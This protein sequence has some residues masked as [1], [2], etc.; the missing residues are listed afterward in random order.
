MSLADEKFMAYFATCAEHIDTQ[1]NN[2]IYKNINL[3]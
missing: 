2:N 3:A 1:N